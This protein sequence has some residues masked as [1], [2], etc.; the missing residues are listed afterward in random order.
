LGVF[1]AM[2]DSLAT[3]WPH[4]LQPLPCAH[5]LTLP[6]PP[7]TYHIGANTDI[8]VP[9][10]PPA[11]LPPSAPPS[12]LLL[13]MTYLPGLVGSSFMPHSVGLPLLPCLDTL[14]AKTPPTPKLL[15]TRA[16][17]YTTCAFSSSSGGKTG[18]LF[19]LEQTDGKDKG[20]RNRRQATG[21]KPFDVLS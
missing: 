12:A 7:V 8:S 16:T 20:G 18:R 5:N 1:R 11:T 13:H 15:Q 21:V 10:G 9:L 6:F 4:L 19:Y 14:S 17:T 3:S 2:G